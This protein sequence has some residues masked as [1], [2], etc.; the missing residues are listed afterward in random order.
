MGEPR[1]RDHTATLEFLG[2]SDHFR[3]GRLDSF[4]YAMRSGRYG[5]SLFSDPFSPSGPRRVD[6]REGSARPCLGCRV[7]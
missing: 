6:S 2:A 5:T 7:M 3:V 1:A 4:P